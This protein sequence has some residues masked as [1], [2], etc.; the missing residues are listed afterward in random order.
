MPIPM[1]KRIIKYFTAIILGSIIV[2]TAYLLISIY[3]LNIVSRNT[4]ITI[5]SKD[6]KESLV[7]HIYVCSYKLSKIT[8]FDSTC[9]SRIPKELFLEKRKSYFPYYFL[10]FGKYEI[11][12]GYFL[13]CASFLNL[14]T[15]GNY[16]IFNNFDVS[17]NDY[18]NI[19]QSSID[20]AYFFYESIEKEVV[21]TFQ[22]MDSKRISSLHYFIE[23]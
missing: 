10:Y 15:C 12:S 17:S 7:N 1:K 18:V 21:L 9:I 20:G 4:S 3:V 19:D 16:Y 13:N 11:Q 14:K 5:H 8:S 23:K 6:K 2:Y 22:D